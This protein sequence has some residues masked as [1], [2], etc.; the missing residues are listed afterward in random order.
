[1]YL[2]VLLWA[3]HASLCV[4]MCLLFLS[5]CFKSFVFVFVFVFLMHLAMGTV[6]SGPWFRTSY[7]FSTLTLDDPSQSSL[8]LPALQPF[9]DD[10]L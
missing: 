7:S 2:H 10:H 6:T 3:L 8:P 5:A 9:T 1:M 4:P